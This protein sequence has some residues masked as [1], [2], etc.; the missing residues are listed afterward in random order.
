MQPVERA[1][2]THGHSDHTR[3]GSRQYYACRAGEEIVRSRLGPDVWLTCFDYRQ[4]WS[5]GE[6]VVSFHPAGHILG[7]AQV[8]IEHCG[9]V[10]VVSGDY[11]RQPDPTCEP[12][13][14][15]PC[16]LFVTE[17][18]FG[19]PVFR[20]PQPSLVFEA[21]HE[22]WRKNQM[23]GKT[24]LLMAYALGKSQRLLA[25]LDPSLGPIYLHGAVSGPT[26]VYRR[27]GIDLPPT[28][29]VSEAP[30]R[31]DWSSALVLAVPSVNG[32]PWMR[33]FGEVSTAMASGWMAIRGTRRRRAIDR[34]LYFRIMSTGLISSTQLSKR[35]LPRFG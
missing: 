23:N 20:W 19:L 2:L 6:V 28:Q 15:V 24:S 12:F 22:W 8:R 18:T 1:V 33:R 4:P 5:I 31:I 10:A 16:D 34:G 17:S 29:W 26:E 21:I 27:V 9:Q 14:V 30:A 13:E 11:K 35:V 3:A 7:S 32:S 25:G